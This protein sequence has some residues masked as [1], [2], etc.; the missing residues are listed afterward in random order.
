MTLRELL[1]DS[2]VDLR[3]YREEIKRRIDTTSMDLRIAEIEKRL[4]APER[5]SN[6]GKVLA[7]GMEILGQITDDKQRQFCSDQIID[8]LAALDD[9]E[10]SEPE[11]PGFP[12]W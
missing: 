6:R 10:K 12:T 11:K 8:L 5:D 3:E 2:L 9:E 7:A 4:A 1:T